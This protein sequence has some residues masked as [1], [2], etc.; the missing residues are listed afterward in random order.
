MA[1]PL[2]GGALGGVSGAFHEDPVFAVESE[3]A[4][5]FNRTFPH[6]EPASMIPI[7]VLTDKLEPAARKAFAERSITAL[8]W[9]NRVSGREMLEWD[10]NEKCSPDGRTL[11]L[12]N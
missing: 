8:A 4:E 11:R 3:E 1:M 2:Y 10:G 5:A 12:R 9:L 7:D 6:K